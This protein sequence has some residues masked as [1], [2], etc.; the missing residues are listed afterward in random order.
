MSVDVLQEKIRKMKNPSVLELAPIFSELP[1]HIA[2]EEATPAAA[3]VRFGKEL[4]EQLR[5]QER[6]KEVKGCVIVRD[7]GKECCLLL[8]KLPQIKFIR[9]REPCNTFKVELLKS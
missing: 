7:D 9:Y 1:P 8:A 5:V 6:H 4:L 2:Q 3:C